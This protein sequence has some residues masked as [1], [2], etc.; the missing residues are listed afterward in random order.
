M[1]EANEELV[2]RSS[3]SKEQR[4]QTRPQAAGR[5]TTAGGNTELTETFTARLYE[6]KETLGNTSVHRRLQSIT[7]HMLPE[8]TN[9]C[10]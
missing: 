4:P 1:W 2:S 9:E 10:Y 6:D 8:S 5:R 3:V 7:M